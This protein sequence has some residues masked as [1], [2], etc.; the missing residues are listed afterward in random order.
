MTDEAA[1][2][3][4]QVVVIVEGST[5]FSGSPAGLAEFARGRVWI[6]AEPAARAL[7]Q[8]RLPDGRHRG[9]GDPPP[10]V[11]VVEPTLEDGYLLLAASSAHP[12]DPQG[13]RCTMP[14]P[15]PVAFDW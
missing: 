8:W 2:V 7:R 1:V 4:R 12:V 11:T 13:Q 5:R 9:I 14:D 10:G 3:A 6:A 15:T